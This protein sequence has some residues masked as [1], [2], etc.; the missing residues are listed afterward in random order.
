VLAKEE[1]SMGLRCSKQKQ[2]ED[3]EHFPFSS[4]LPIF[5]FG[6]TGV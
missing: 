5:V 1:D 3:L 2:S 6:E 4:I